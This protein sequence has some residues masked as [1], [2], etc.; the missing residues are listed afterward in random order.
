MTTTFHTRSLIFRGS[1]SDITRKYVYFI[2]MRVRANTRAFTLVEILIVIGVLAILAVV[3]VAAINPAGRINASQDAQTRRNVQEL[4]QAAR[5]YS[6]DN[7][8]ALP[9]SNGTDLPVVTEETVIAS[10]VDSATLDG[11]RGVY[12]SSL[13]PRPNGVNYYV[14]QTADGNILVGA[15]MSNGFLF[16]NISGE[17]STIVVDGGGAGGGGEEEPADY[18]TVDYVVRTQWGN[19]FVVDLTIHNIS[20]AAIDGWQLDWTFDGDQVITNPWNFQITQNGQNVSAVNMPYN[21][22]IASGSS[23]L[24][25]FQASYSGSNSALD[26][27]QFSLNGIPCQ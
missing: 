27:N 12:L 11:I 4:S 13:P 17:S 5:L 25:G 1:L 24:T 23:T 7:G 15:G 21:S 3:V 16:T 22:V 18:C 6:V 8:G 19:G 9:T 20:D 14:G 10:G 26:S 2:Y